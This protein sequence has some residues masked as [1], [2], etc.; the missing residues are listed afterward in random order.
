MYKNSWKIIDMH[1]DP[2]EGAQEGKAFSLLFFAII[3]LQQPATADSTSSLVV[4][5]L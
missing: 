2:G 5:R 3:I 4:K 1:V